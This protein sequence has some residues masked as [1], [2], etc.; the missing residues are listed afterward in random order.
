MLYIAVKIFVKKFES[1]IKIERERV[2]KSNPRHS[3]QIGK[4]P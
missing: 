2:P 1:K 4:Y 3:F